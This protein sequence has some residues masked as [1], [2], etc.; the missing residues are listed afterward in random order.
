V[1]LMLLLVVAALAS[2]AAAATS[3]SHSGGYT[4]EAEADRVTRL[5]GAPRGALDAFG[6]FSG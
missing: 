4:R 3:G 1:L 6:L 2:A 5:P